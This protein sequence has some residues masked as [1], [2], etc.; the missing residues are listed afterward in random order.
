MYVQGSV[1]V[2]SCI[3]HKQALF[4]SQQVSSPCLGSGQCSR[5]YFSLVMFGYY[6]ISVAWFSNAS[7]PKK[8]F[9]FI[10]RND[11]CEKTTKSIMKDV[12]KLSAVKPQGLKTFYYKATSRGQLGC[13]HCRIYVG[14]RRCLFEWLLIY[15]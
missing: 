2:C 10:M 11:L 14:G 12:A 6:F 3:E 1:K 15:I 5:F 4:Q 7:V 8:A 9:V 13:T